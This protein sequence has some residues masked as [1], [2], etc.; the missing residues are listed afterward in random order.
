M[1]A[2]ATGMV[3]HEPVLQCGKST[4]FSVDLAFTDL[5]SILVKAQ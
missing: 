5:R 3:V 2:T 1:A 4:G